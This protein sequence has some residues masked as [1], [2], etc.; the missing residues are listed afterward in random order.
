MAKKEI[1]IS[2]LDNLECIDRFSYLGD[3]IGAS[4]GAEEVVNYQDSRAR[5]DCAWASSKA[6]SSAN[7]KGSLKDKYKGPVFRVSWD[8]RVKLWL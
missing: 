7:I 1:I 5:V 6:G 2:S 4:G 3:F 8:M